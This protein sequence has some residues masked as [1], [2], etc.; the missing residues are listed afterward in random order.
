[1]ATNEIDTEDAAVFAL[2]GL[3]AAATVGIADV[4]LFGYAFSDPMPYLNMENL[5][6]AT[7]ISLAAFAWVWYTN[8]PDLD[9]MDDNYTYAVM[10]TLALIVAIPLVP[11]IADL[12]MAN[13]ALA[14][15]AVAIQS[16]GVV[17]V[18]Y[19]A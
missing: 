14:L 8:E 17:I 15:G 12:V 5:S 11:Q 19:E 16:A 7:G 6:I 2:F 3:A 4:T 9:R 18:S 10:G 13:D 1:M